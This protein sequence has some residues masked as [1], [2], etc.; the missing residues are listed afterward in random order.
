MIEDN[1]TVGF[2]NRAE[3]FRLLLAREWYRRK[4]LGA[5][6]ASVWQT[7][8]RIGAKKKAQVAQ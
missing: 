3:F 8:S 7:A 6:P 2:E 4:G 5:P 1:E